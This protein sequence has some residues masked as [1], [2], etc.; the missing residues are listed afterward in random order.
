MEIIRENEQLVVRGMRSGED[1]EVI[2]NAVRDFITAEI[3]V[4]IPCLSVD[5]IKEAWLAGKRLFWH[6]HYDRL[7]WPDTDSPLEIVDVWYSDMLRGD[8]VIFYKCQRIDCPRCHDPKAKWSSHFKIIRSDGLDGAGA[9][10]EV[11][12]RR[13]KKRETEVILVD[14]P[15][16]VLG[17]PRQETVEG[18]SHGESSEDGTS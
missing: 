9:G 5:M 10:L 8:S 14:Q 15:V 7:A 18:I 12:I 13:G 17:C 4:G 3:A 11:E 1:R 2:E 16:F 6:P